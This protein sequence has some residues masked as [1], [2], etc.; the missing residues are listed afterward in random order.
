MLYLALVLVALFVLSSEAMAQPYQVVTS[1][2]SVSNPGAVGSGMGG[3]IDTNG[4]IC[5]S[6]S[7]S[8]LTGANA[9]GATAIP[10]GAPSSATLAALAAQQGVLLDT[11]KVAGDADDTASMTRAVAAGVCVL[12]GPRTYTINNYSMAG[13]PASFC[14]KGVKGQSVIQR[15]SASGSQFFN[16]TATNSYLDGVTFDMNKAAV[17]ANQWGVFFSQG[18]QTVSITH[19]VFENNSGSLSVGLALRSTAANDGGSFNISDDE[20]SGNV[21]S[22]GGA[23]YLATASHGVVSR[24]FVHDNTGNGIFAQANGT[25]TAT[26]YITDVIISDN[27]VERNGGTGIGVGGFS[28][29]Y[30][31]AIPPATY[32][33]IEH[34]SMID[35]ANYGILME[36]AYLKANDNQVLQS[37]PSVIVYGGIDN[38]GTYS[39]IQHNTVI[40][41]GPNWGI[42]IGGS[43]QTT[44]QNNLV[45]MTQGSAFN[46]GGNVNSLVTDNHAIISGT[47]VGFSVEATESGGGAVFPNLTTGLVI[48]SNL[49][50]MVGGSVTGV[51]L[52]DNPGGY[53][54][55]TSTV[56]RRNSFNGSGGTSPANAIVWYGSTASLIIEGNLYNGGNRQFVDPNAGTVAFDN[57]YYGGTVSGSSSTSTVVT[58]LPRPFLAY[59]A[60]T[61][62]LYVTPTAGGANY[63]PATTTI[64]ISGA[65]CT[66]QA[67][68]PMIINGAITG[69][70]MNGNFGSGCTGTVT[71]AAVDTSLSGS[72]A[73]FTVGTVPSL[74]VSATLTY[75]GN[76]NY[77]LLQHSG[78][79]VPI[80]G[81]PIIMSANGSV[82]LQAKSN[83]SWALI[84]YTIAVLPSTGLPT[85]N[86]T[87]SGAIVTVT[88]ALTPTYGGTLTGGGAVRVP[89]VECN[90]TNWITY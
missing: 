33:L 25:A 51:S 22:V 5:V 76:T 30:S 47:A 58:I 23:L 11:F 8:N 17:T 43:T 70:R 55:A 21:A 19:C 56:V 86:A 72:G 84:N 64:Q 54:G 37:S 49:I 27:R 80:G 69:A 13:T 26:N 12:L 71:A 35:N 45:S 81:P 16:V 39:L 52:L 36:G 59:G 79:Y 88:D 38:N 24:N 2:G 42:D 53:P 83:N 48:E 73:T 3:Y 82:Q 41:A 65:G 50:D 74:P 85:C 15:T 66:G 29:P 7:G 63:N 40:L 77:Y 90:G 4:N 62:V 1:C 46:V 61:S 32:V 34:N 31:Y 28:P 89:S 9:S 75:L 44:L 67:V 20:F 87:S 78:N 6:A 68:T 18:S 57:V 14:L 60:G 10:T